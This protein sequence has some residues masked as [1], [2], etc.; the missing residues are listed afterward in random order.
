MADLNKLYIV[1]GR[2]VTLGKLLEAWL[3]KQEEAKAVWTTRYMNDLPDSCF[4]YV[5]SGGKKDSEGKTVP[6]GLRHFP[7]KDINGK[8]DLPHVRNAIARIPQSNAPGLTAEKKRS[9]Q[10][11]ARRILAEAQ[12]GSPTARDVHVP[13]AMN[14]EEEDMEKAEWQVDILKAD[15][16]KRLVY[17]AVLV[18]NKVDS[19]D[20]RVSEE[21]VEKAAHGYLV[22]KLSQQSSALDEQHQTELSIEKARPVES[23]VLLE[24]MTL[25][26]KELPKG[27][28]VLVTHVPDD[29]LWGKIKKK[30]IN[31]FSIRG[32]GRRKRVA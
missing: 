24:T 32:I 2:V 15:E 8:I 28:W 30:E 21:E 11:R 20:D 9:L 29:E 18:P 14:E 23:Y 1:N 12:K 27:T 5:E 16:E 7:Y 10:E 25:G 17:G 22:R 13:G 6:R 4:L 3:E 31:G 26:E 19:Q